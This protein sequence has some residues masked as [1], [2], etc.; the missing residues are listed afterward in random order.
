[1]ESNEPAVVSEYLR[2]EKCIK[3]YNVSVDSKITCSL[4]SDQKFVFSSVFS[5]NEAL[6]EHLLKFSKSK[7][8]YFFATIF[9]WLEKSQN[10]MQINFENCKRAFILAFMKCSLIDPYCA[11][12]KKQSNRGDSVAHASLNLKVIETN[13][14]NELIDLFFEP[15]TVFSQ[16]TSQSLLTKS[17]E[18]SN[19]YVKDLKVK[20]SAVTSIE[21]NT[22]INLALIHHLCEFQAIY[23]SINYIRE[24]V[25]AIEPNVNTIDLIELNCFFNAS[26]IH[27][28][29]ILLN[30]RPNPD[31]YI[32]ELLGRKSFFKY[33][34]NN[35]LKLY[36]DMFL[37]KE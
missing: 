23:L 19:E 6:S 4:F 26:F 30:K 17:S 35:L 21:K 8:I 18:I 9:G 15:K 31:L 16:F 7:L 12:L 29:V 37:I 34:Y 22:S 5:L 10:L 33:L 3:I 11:E 27:N 25:N 1:M 20:L 32:E 2:C 14:N 13:D 24:L 36:D 28:F